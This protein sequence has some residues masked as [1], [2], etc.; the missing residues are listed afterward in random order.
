[1]YTSSSKCSMFTII[2]ALIALVAGIF[3]GYRFYTFSPWYPT[4]H[5]AIAVIHPTEG[6]K[7]QGIATF[8]QEKDGLHISVTCNNLTPGKHGLH[9]H[10]FGD[11]RNT[12]SFCNHF[13]PINK[14]HGGPASAERHVGDLGNIEADASGA[15]R[16]E[17]VDKE[18]S[19]NGPHSIIGR[20]VLV[21]ADADDLTSQPSGN[22]GARIGYGVIGIMGK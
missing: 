14:R 3:I 19:L 8:S 21:H 13:N 12:E 6:N 18:L 1:M 20:S 11:A 7:V 5:R 15:A 10:C 16:Y 2:S 4:V 17:L 9:I 22:S